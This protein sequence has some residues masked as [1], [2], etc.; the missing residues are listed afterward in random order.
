[1]LRL[2]SGLILTLIIATVGCQNP[3]NTSDMLESSAGVERMRAVARLSDEHR[4][5]NVPVFI[6]HLEDPDVSVRWA[7]IQSLEAQVGTDFG[8]RY[9]DPPEHRAAAVERWQH[10]WQTEGNRGPQVRPSSAAS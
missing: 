6:R 2:L 3:P 7:A 4:W 5:S 1:M 9:N 8:F 10:W